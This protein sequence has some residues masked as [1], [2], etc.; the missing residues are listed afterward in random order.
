MTR[1]T[2]RLERAALRHVDTIF[3][4]NAEMVAHVRRHA[5]DA[6]VLLAPQGVDTQLF[7]PTAAPPRGGPILCVGR[8]D[9]PRKNLPLLFDAYARLRQRVPDAPRLVLAGNT[10]PA[11][12]DWRAAEVAGVRGHTDFRERLPRS[13]LAQLFRSSSLFVQDRS[14]Y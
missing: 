9:D 7:R 13:E 5:P 3:A 4:L 2:A 10:R 8:F 6:E 12:S 1:V 11:R 14:E